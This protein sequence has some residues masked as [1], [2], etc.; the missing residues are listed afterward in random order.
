MSR[1]NTMDYI[2]GSGFAMTGYPV[3]AL[4]SIPFV[5]LNEN[6]YPMFINEKGNVTT[7]AIN[8]QER[9]NNSYLKY[10]GPTDPVYT[11]SLGNIFTYKGFR[12]N[13]FLTYSFGN[14]V[15]LDP[16]FSY[17]YNDL[18][19]MTK[20]FKNRWMMPGD[21]KI[22]NVPVI[23]SKREYNDNYELVYGYNAYNYSTERVAKGDFIRMKEISFGYDFPSKWFKGMALNSLSVKLQGTDLFLIY[24]DKKLNGQD[25]EFFR[26]GGVSAPMPKQFTLT[27]KAGF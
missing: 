24:A 15:R 3:R 18:S 11:G 17:K 14:V 7:T 5:G 25:P 20:E 6:G 22:T 23:L 19:S 4:F 21:E 12:L 26:A 9:D 27:V 10:E 16:V 8:F 2:S 1:A 13:I